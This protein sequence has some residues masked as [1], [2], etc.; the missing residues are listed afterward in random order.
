MLCIVMATDNASKGALVLYG[1]GAI[2]VGGAG[3]AMALR[4][5]PFTRRLSRIG[6][7]MSSAVI[8]AAGITMVVLGVARML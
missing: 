1:I 6:N 8:L 3:L 5:R 7:G 2:I 4:G